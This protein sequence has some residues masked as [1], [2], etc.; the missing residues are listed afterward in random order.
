[1]YLPG[2]A[3]ARGRTHTH[4]THTHTPVYADFL[5]RSGDALA[6]LYNDQSPME[7]HQ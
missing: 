4:N 2:S 3:C 1:M 5:V 7:N 6:L